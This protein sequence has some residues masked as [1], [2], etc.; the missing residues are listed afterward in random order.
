MLNSKLPTEVELI[1]EVMPCNSMRCSQ[2]PIKT[3]HPCNYFR[4]WGTYHSYDYAMDGPPPSHDIVQDSV[5]LGKATLLPEVLSGCRK[6]P[7]M[8]VGINP[9]L[10]AFW[11]TN[12]NSVYPLFDD[13]KQYAHYFRYRATAKLEI[14]EANYSQYGGGA[15][16][17]PFSDFELNVP[18]D[19]NGKK[20]IPTSI[21]NQRMYLA[22]QELLNSFALKM[23]WNN[24]K[25]SV[26]EDLSYGNMVACSSARWTTVADPQNPTLPPMTTNERN[27]IV[28]ECFFDRKHF[29][30]QF[31]Q[32]QPKVV[33][34]FSQN[35]ANAFI[36]SLK[37]NF[38][39]GNPQ[40]SEPI[41]QLLLRTHRIKLG[42]FPNGQEI[43]SR[44]IF[45]PHPTGNP[46]DYEPVK[47][48]IIDYLV[49]EGNT[50]NL[51]LNTNT[52]HLKRTI[53]SCVFCPM[54]EIGKCDYENEIIPAVA[55]D[56]IMRPDFENLIVEEK[57]H[58][59][60]LLENSL[61]LNFNPSEWN[62]ETK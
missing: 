14:P 9:N 24:H 50:N 19:A 52:G 30:R 10:P 35:T 5:Y 33:L 8:A 25:L 56:H 28:K 21:Q 39:E 62:E 46:G 37:G 2:E 40:V 48:K 41:D 7:I 18:T 34:V 45:C 4:K 60:S 20:T 32:S 49:E 38:I 57:R 61:Q 17:E 53:G 54:L 42:N 55:I 59:V 12:R 51:E 26:G 15:A 43:V 27:G 6:S 36:S 22:Y 13:Y 16:D 1:Y 11:K 31:F 44:V 47:Q 23:G 58:Q 3:N 29:L